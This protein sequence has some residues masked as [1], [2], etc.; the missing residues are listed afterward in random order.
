MACFSFIVFIAFSLTPLIFFKQL[1]VFETFIC[2][3]ETSRP[4]R[5]TCLP[6]LDLGL[7]ER[8][9]DLN[10]PALRSAVSPLKTSLHSKKYTPKLK[11]FLPIFLLQC[12]F[13]RNAE[14]FLVKFLFF[15]S[16][17]INQRRSNT[18]RHFYPLL[19]VNQAADTGNSSRLLWL[20]TNADKQ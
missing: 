6:D 18:S 13:F 19:F 4:S 20:R 15:S 11:G 3:P 9:T 14:L 12:C 7:R 10:S 8:Q 1:V 5:W 17:L 2:L 16:I